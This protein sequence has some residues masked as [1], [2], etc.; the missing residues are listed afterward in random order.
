MTAIV[1]N[2]KA[3]TISHF[4]KKHVSQLH[5]LAL[6]T[7]VLLSDMMALYES[8]KIRSL[9][10]LMSTLLGILFCKNKRK[11]NLFSNCKIKSNITKQFADSHKCKTIII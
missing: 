8:S 2:Y 3:S 4:P 10:T 1:L 5:Y 7:S 6:S 11:K 9:E